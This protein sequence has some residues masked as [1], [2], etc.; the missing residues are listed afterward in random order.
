M[1]RVAN[2]LVPPYRCICRIVARAYDKPENEYSVGTG[3]LIGPYHVLTCAHNIYP[4]QAPRTE[5]IDVYPAQNGPDESASRFRANGWAV[6]RGWSPN[7]C[8]AAGEDYG[9]IRLASPAP[10]GFFA[11]RTFDPAIVIGKTVHLAGYPGSNREPR[12]RYM[13]RS[14]GTVAGAIV[15][16]GCGR[17]ARGNDTLRGRI[18]PSILPTTSLVA[19]DLPAAH[20]VSGGPV[21]IEEDGTRTLVAL[22][23]RS[24]DEGRRRA[25]V[26]LN[27][28]VRAQAARW[29]NNDLPPLRR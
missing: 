27:A 12:A 2:A 19:H 8:R 6:S 20:A 1:V 23:A 3:V 29:I 24:I 16:E 21:W 25:A 17:D 22:H 7:D 4:L 9:I 18:V 28:G 5:T 26:L 13:Y 15:I 14:A 10:H 11:L